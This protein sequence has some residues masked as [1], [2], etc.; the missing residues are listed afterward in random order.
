MNRNSLTCQDFDGPLRQ[1]PL[2]E[3]TP[4]YSPIKHIDVAIGR[5]VP[6]VHLC[7]I[8]EPIHAHRV[9]IELRPPYQP[10]VRH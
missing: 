7:E 2:L 8:R 6:A 3:S 5:E 4:S 1:E 9:H 10:Y